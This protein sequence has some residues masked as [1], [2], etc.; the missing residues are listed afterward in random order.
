[1]ARDYDGDNR[2]DI[3]VFRPGTGTWYTLTSSS[4]YVSWT[5]VQFGQTGDRVV[6]GDYDGDS[7]ADIAVQRPGDGAWHIVRSSTGA[8]YTVLF[9][10]PEFPVPGAYLTPLY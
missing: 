7:K 3:A 8:Y 6:P 2:T 1:M 9:V 4:N 5:S 10:S